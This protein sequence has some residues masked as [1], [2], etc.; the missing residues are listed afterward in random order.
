MSLPTRLETARLVLRPPTLDDAAWIFERYAR[1]PEVTR[2]LQWSPHTER[3]TVVA[4]LE[5]VVDRPDGDVQWVIEEHGRGLGM[6]GARAVGP[7]HRELGYVLAREAWGRGLMTEATRA[8]SEACLAEPLVCRVSAYADIDNRAS[9][10]VLEKAG[11]EREGVL[12]RFAFHPNVS[13]RPR[14]CVLMSRVV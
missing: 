8:V 1:D 13:P 7:H 6:I 14:D 10:R 9:Q 4:F 5:T 3:G 11:F 12:R 2:Y